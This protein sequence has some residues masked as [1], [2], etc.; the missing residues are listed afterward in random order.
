MAGDRCDKCDKVSA[1]YHYI[2]NPATGRLD[3]VFVSR[4]AGSGEL[5]FCTE[6]CC[7]EYTKF[8]DECSQ[9]CKKNKN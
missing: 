6:Y 3:E 9:Y 2:F 7:Q 4:K 8:C 5:I 1:V